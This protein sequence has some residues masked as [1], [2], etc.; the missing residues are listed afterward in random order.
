[1]TTTTM[2]S[3]LTAQN[4]D[5]LGDSFSFACND[6]DDHDD[7]VSDAESYIEI[8]VQQPKHRDSFHR[9]TKSAKEEFTFERDWVGTGCCDEAEDEEEEEDDDHIEVRISI[10]SAVLLPRISPQCFNEAIKAIESRMGYLEEKQNEEPSSL[11]IRKGGAKWGK[12]RFP[13]V[14]RVLGTFF[15]NLKVTP[16]ICH[17]QEKDVF[18]VISK[19]KNKKL[20]V[21]RP[22]NTTRALQ[23][24]ERRVTKFLIKVRGMQIRP[25]LSSVL[26]NCQVAGSRPKLGNKGQAKNRGIEDTVQCYRRVPSK[27][28]RQGSLGESRK[29]RDLGRKVSAVS[30]PSSISSSPIN[31][32]QGYGDRK[33]YMADISVQAAIAHCKS[34]FNPFPGFSFPPYV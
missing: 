11:V 33:G 23:A 8:L 6:L 32:T 13:A 15:S 19:R 16:E 2:S 20:V 5:E 14:K 4:R 30:C 18:N 31:R 7:D 21:L 25:F 24:T 3:E 22:S 34:S 12:I 29:D 27:V 17:T 1:M 28:F 26:K 9:E 10:S